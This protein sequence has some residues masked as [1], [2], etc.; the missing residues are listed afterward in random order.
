MSNTVRKGKMQKKLFREEKGGAKKATKKGK[1]RR[2][3]NLP[4][5]IRIRGVRTWGGKKRKRSSK[6]K[7]DEKER[8]GVRATQPL[9]R[10]GSYG[11][12]QNF[13]TR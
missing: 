9:S 13:A 4:R 6:K 1:R 8:R 7:D 12:G 3:R 2:L 11:G 5:D 10:M